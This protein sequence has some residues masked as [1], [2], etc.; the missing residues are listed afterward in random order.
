MLGVNVANWRTTFPSKDN[1]I[2]RKGF[3]QILST[4][5]RKQLMTSEKLHARYILVKRECLDRLCPFGFI[6]IYKLKLY[7]ITP[8]NLLLCIRDAQLGTLRNIL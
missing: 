7:P 3:K 4:K 8:D 2:E 5:F 1:R 6:G